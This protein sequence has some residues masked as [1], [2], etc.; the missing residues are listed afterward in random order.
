MIWHYKRKNTVSTD[1][2]YYLAHCL[3][4]FQNIFN[5][6][7]CFSV[8]FAF[9][10]KIVKLQVDPLLFCIV[11]DSGTQ[12]FLRRPSCFLSEGSSFNQSAVQP[13]H[14]H[15]L[16]TDKVFTLHAVWRVSA[17]FLLIILH[18]F[19]R[20]LFLVKALYRSITTTEN[21]SRILVRKRNHNL[22]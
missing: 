4:N 15:V 18:V 3:H 2:T 16:V 19:L 7:L 20:G 1:L 22:C 8:Y 5:D 10:S 11:V 21:W 14:F 6:H 12:E 13:L 17:M 9:K